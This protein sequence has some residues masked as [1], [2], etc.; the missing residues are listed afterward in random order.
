[1]VEARIN[2]GIN[3]YGRI[4]RTFHR[5]AIQDPSIHIAAINSRTDAETMTHLLKYDSVYGRLDAEVEVT[6]SGFSVYGEEIQVYQEP[7]PESIPWAVHDIDIIIESTGKFKDLRST[8]A[9]LEGG[10][11]HVIVCCPPKSDA[12]PAIVMGVNEQT[13]NLEQTPVISNASC[14][15]NALAP[16]LRVLDEAYGIEFCSFRTIHA[17]TDSQHLLDNADANPRYARG[18]FESI[19]PTSTGASDMVKRLFPHLQGKVNGLAYRV[20]TR[21]VSN[22]DLCVKLIKPVTTNQINL[23]FVEA[24]NGEMNGIVGVTDEPLVSIDFSGDASSVTVDLGLTTDCGD[25]LFNLAGWYDN[26]WGYSARVLDLVH[27][28]AHNTIAFDEYEKSSAL[29][30]S[31]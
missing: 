19:I 21:T 14:T 25:G 30:L 22:I 17:I 11:Q 10:G 3:G 26:E 20:P 8:A 27:Y 2:V 31:A 9:H 24:A 13:V 15:T 29:S 5:L 12:I 7:S 1:M 18:A 16:M 23:C 28:V 4:G 6:D